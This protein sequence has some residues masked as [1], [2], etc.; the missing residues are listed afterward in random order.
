MLDA[1]ARVSDLVGAHG[2][3]A[4][5]DQLVVG[6][7]G[8]HQLD[9]A[10][11]LVEA[12]PIVAPQRFIGEIVEI[13][14]LE[15][16]ELAARRGKQLLAGLDVI[17]HRAAD[18]EQQQYLHHV[19]PLRHHLDVEPAA[20]ARRRVD[21]VGQGELGGRAAPREAPQPAQRQLHVARAELDRI[22]EVREFAPVP[23]LDRAAIA[24]PILADAHALPGCS[25][26]R[27]TA[28]CRPCRSI[29]CRPDAVP[30][31]SSRRFLSVSISLS[32]PPSASICAFSSS[33]EVALRHLLEPV[34]RA[35]RAPAVANTSSAPLKCAREHAVE[36]I[37]VRSSLTR[38]AR[39][40]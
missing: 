33:R 22:V 21:G 9:G 15:M 36:S 8:A 38:Q 13:E 34:G 7:V 40:R 31:C 14:M 28:R 11:V 6:R 39:A 23:D 5:Q 4:H 16:L 32:Q 20:G 10:D 18:I 37:V 3:I 12:P 1:A 29:C 26:R 30:C 19:V 2:R 25:R 24:R 27:R 35:A 17:V